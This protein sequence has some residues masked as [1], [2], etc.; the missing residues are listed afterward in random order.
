MGLGMFATSSHAVPPRYGSQAILSTFWT[1][2]VVWWIVV[3]NDT[4]VQATLGG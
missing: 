4:V 2:L 1:F 3:T